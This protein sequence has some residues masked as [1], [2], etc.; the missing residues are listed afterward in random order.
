[1]RAPP[2]T[3]SVALTL[4]GGCLV[5]PAD[6]ELAYDRD[7]DGRQAVEVG[8]DDCDDGA[9]DVHPGAEE[10]CLDDVDSDCDGLGCPARVDVLL[11]DD[12]VWAWGEAG[13]H[14]GWDA[15]VADLDGDGTPELLVGLDASDDSEGAVV[16][17]TLPRTDP[18]DLAADAA[19]WFDA[20]VNGGLR[21]SSAG[22]LDGD[23]DADVAISSTGRIARVW[24][25]DDVPVDGGASDADGIL[26]VADEERRPDDAL[27]DTTAP[28]REF[29]RVVGLGDRD[30]DG[31]G[32]WLLS[33][34]GYSAEGTRR[35]AVFLISGIPSGTIEAPSVAITTFH[36]GEE[37]HALSLPDTGSCPDLD[38]DGRPD[39]LLEAPGYRAPEL[40][41]AGNLTVTPGGVFGF[42]GDPSGDVRLDDAELRIVSIVGNSSIAR[43]ARAGDVDGDGYDDVGA[44]YGAGVGE[45]LVFLGPLSGNLYPNDANVR[46]IGGVGDTLTDAFADQWSGEV[47][48]DADGRDDLLVSATLEGTAGLG[49]GPDQSGATYLFLGPLTGVQNPDHARIRWVGAFEGGEQG[50][51]IAHDF[52]GD[53]ALDLLLG[54]EG[55]WPEPSE[56]PGSP[57]AL[58]LVDDAFGGL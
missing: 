26:T 56:S 52:S 53:G 46:L 4:A 24:V 58:L 15:G 51:A 57:G 44:W 17:V 20:R 31:G 14:L 45:M 1:M 19:G 11:G 6:R 23:G 32:E 8:G 34:P 36:G 35:G 10:S 55:A 28:G 37:D 16:R 49:A 39:P 48:V 2:T 54:A 40:G 9:P 25:L 29:G 7:H 27:P 5:T 30:G 18:F 33:S 21:A 22:D 38:G 42:S 50:L 47:D 41:S 13:A 12:D 43:A 3:L